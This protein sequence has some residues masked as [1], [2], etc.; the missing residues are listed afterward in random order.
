MS[1]KLNALPAA[2]IAGAVATAVSSVSMPDN[3]QAAAQEK[4][5]G[6]A[7][8]GKNDCESGPGTTCAGTSKVNY[9]GN[10]WILVPAGTCK[11]YGD[12]TEASSKYYLPDGLK[13][14]TTALT[15]NLPP[16]S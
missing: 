15:T 3:A 10:A 7:M 1:R 8:A 2:V 14:S 5:Y 16:K 9:Q 6:I 13:G 11:D 12:T 4:C